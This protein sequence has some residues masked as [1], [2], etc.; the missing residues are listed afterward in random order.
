MFAWRLGGRSCRRVNRPLRPWFLVEGLGFGGLGWPWA[1]SP[2][3]MVGWPCN[4]SDLGPHRDRGMLSAAGPIGKRSSG[5]RVLAVPRGILTVSSIVCADG[6][7][8]SF[9]EALVRR[10]RPAS[11][12]E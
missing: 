5:D 7:A 9:A 6:R 8:G 12:A 4:H 1:P 10:S 3:A 2:S 11:P